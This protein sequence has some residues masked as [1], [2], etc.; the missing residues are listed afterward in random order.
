MTGRRPERDWGVEYDSGDLFMSL[1]DVPDDSLWDSNDGRVQN[2]RNVFSSKAQQKPAVTDFGPSSFSNFLHAEIDK[3]NT[4]EKPANGKGKE[5]VREYNYVDST[6]RTSQVQ[7]TAFDHGHILKSKFS[8]K[9]DESPCFKPSEITTKLTLAK[10]ALLHLRGLKPQ[11]KKPIAN[12]QLSAPPSASAVSSHDATGK[13]TSIPGRPRAAVKRAR[14]ATAPDRQPSQPNTRQVFGTA[15]Y[16][17]FAQHTQAVRSRTR[18]Q[19]GQQSGPTLGLGHDGSADSVNLTLPRLNLRRSRL[20]QLALSRLPPANESD[21]D[22]D[23]GS[24]TRPLSSSMLTQDGQADTVAISTFDVSDDEDAVDELGGELQYLATDDSDL[25]DFSDAFEDAGEPGD[26]PN[27]NAD[28]AGLETLFDSSPTFESYESG[29]RSDVFPTRRVGFQKFEYSHVVPRSKPKVCWDALTG[30]CNFVKLLRKGVYCNHSVDARPLPAILANGTMQSRLSKSEKKSVKAG[31][32]Y[33][34]KNNASVRTWIARPPASSI[35]A[36]PICHPD[37]AAPPRNTRPGYE[38]APLPFTYDNW[39]SVVKYL[40]FIDIQNLRLTCKVFAKELVPHMLRSAVPEF[41]KSMFTPHLDLLNPPIDEKTGQYKVPVAKSMFEKYGKEIHKFGIAFDV[42]L[43]G[44]AFARPKVT[45][46][47]EQAWY[48]SYRWPVE[49]YPRFT[50]LQEL[51]DLLDDNRHLLTESFSHLVKASELALSLD[52]GHGWLNGPDISDLELFDL[53]RARGTKVFGET[54]QEDVWHTLG[55]SEFF[56]WGQENTINEILRVLLTKPLTSIVVRQ[57]GELRSV[58]VRE[59]DSF[60]DEKSQHDYDCFS[61]TGGQSLQSLPQQPQ[62]PGNPQLIAGTHQ[63]ALT[64][65]QNLQAAFQTLA[66]IVPPAHMA[67]MSLSSNVRHDHRHLGNRKCRMNKCKCIREIPLQWPIIFNAYN[68]AADVGGRSPCIQNKVA[69]PARFPLIPGC[70][71]EAQVQ[72]LM[73]TAWAQRA[74]LSAYTTAVITNSHNLSGVHTLTLAKL[75]SGLLPSLAQKEFWA[76]LP[77]LKRLKILISPDWRNE[78]VPGDKFFASHMAISPVTAAMKFVDFL[79]QYVANQENLSRLTV[80]YIGG[81]EKAT[82]MFARNQHLLP[83]PIVDDPASWVTDHVKKPDPLTMMRFDHIR[84]LTFENCWFSPCMLE[85]FMEK[86]R[87]TSLHTLTF[88]SVSMLSRHSTGTDGP[89]Q[90]VR[91]GLRTRFDETDWLHEEVPSSATWTEVLD[92][93]TPGATMAERKYAAGILDKQATPVPSREFR[94]NVQKIVLKSCGYAKVSGFK[95]DEFNQNALVMHT[96]N[97]MDQG[98]QARRR[99]FDQF[100]SALRAE[101][102]EIDQDDDDDDANGTPHTSRV[103]RVV[104]YTVRGGARRGSVPRPARELAVMMSMINPSTAAEWVGLGTLTQ[105]IHPVEKRVLEQAWGMSFGWGD[106]IERWTA[107]EDGFFPG[108]TGR[109]SGVIEG[110]TVGDGG[111]S[112]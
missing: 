76:S 104:P 105:C 23:S 52:S 66:A 61:H 93:I 55:R 79:R 94:G 19:H 69:G 26:V 54:F 48:G 34:I 101:E 18:S 41:G 6:V 81:G 11:D 59:Y 32:R 17:E 21:G 71:T 74:F 90:T 33:M 10:D 40:S 29:D 110:G 39:F 63:F 46:K 112:V 58:K 51:E 15:R 89:L 31:T 49:T 97:P 43:I 12:L 88:D 73:E 111:A 103:I 50:D 75:S 91:N 98:L 45:E 22:G 62:A 44:L 9:V 80:G 60:A 108:G 2:L 7:S 95:G 27:S 86:S 53:R 67:Q 84:E 13:E 1:S 36:P 16:H 100:S 42:D 87:D 57:I 4:A 68:L 83:A 78:H 24:S 109:F 64:H 96:T 3:A 28:D 106:R 8:T 56:K 107:V 99:M 37:P 92:K 65:T 70:L 38:E 14:P 5:P 102:D 47:R 20:A 77:G 72:W 35:M 85:A 30:S 25:D 82:G